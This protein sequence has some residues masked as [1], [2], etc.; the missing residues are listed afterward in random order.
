MKQ[1][2]HVA[3]FHPAFFSLTRSEKPLPSPLQRWH[4]P[5]WGP[6]SPSR[7]SSFLRGGGGVRR[8]HLPC[9]HFLYTVQHPTVFL[10]GGWLYLRPWRPS[11]LPKAGMLDRSRDAV[12][13]HLDFIWLCSGEEG[14]PLSWCI[15][16]PFA[17]SSILC[18]LV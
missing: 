1:P 6:T 7:F 12:L 18:L 11:P 13:P 16:C 4:A 2:L 3:G 8:P 5:P 17:F 9:T 10:L 14:A 15:S